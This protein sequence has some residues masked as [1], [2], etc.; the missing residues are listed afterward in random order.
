MAERVHYDLRSK[1]VVAQ[2]VFTPAD[3]PLSFAGSEAG[4]FLNR[5]PTASIVGIFGWDGRQLLQCFHQN[6]I[7]SRGLPEFSLER[8]SRQDAESRCHVDVILPI[9]PA[10]HEV[11][12]EIW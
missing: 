5:M 7:V 11:Q 8:R 2:T 9:W 1:N 10:A 3:S 4:K 12:L 6:L